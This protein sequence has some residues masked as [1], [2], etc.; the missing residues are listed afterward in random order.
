MGQSFRQEYYKGQAEDDF[1]ILDLADQVKT[2]GATSDQAMLTKEWT[3][4]EPNV[5]D[6]KYYVHGVGTALEKTAKGPLERNTSFG[7]Q[8]LSA[9]AIEAHGLAKAYGEICAVEALDLPYRQGSC[10]ASSA[11]TEPARRRRFAC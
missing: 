3:P 6:D 9:S 8:G 11:R 2:P 5:L 1:R 4:L 7:A 10:S